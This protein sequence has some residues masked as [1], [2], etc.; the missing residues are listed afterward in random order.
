MKG[1]RVIIFAVLLF[2][3]AISSAAP[4]VVHAQDQSSS[5]NGHSYSSILSASIT[6]SA[7][8]QSGSL[9]LSPGGAVYLYAA[10]TGGGQPISGESYAVDLFVSN[11]NQYIVGPVIAIGHSSNNTGS[12]STA[13]SYYAIGG[14]RVTS[15]IY[16]NYTFFNDSTGANSTSGSFSVTQNG[17]LVVLVSAASNGYSGAVTSNAPF[18]YDAVTSGT[19]GN[20]SSYSGIVI[21]SATVGRGQYSFT[22]NYENG[23]GSSYA[24]SV[25]A[26]IYIFSQVSAREYNVTFSESGLPS[27]SSWYVNLSNGLSYDSS[28]SLISFSA[29]NGTYYYS[30]GSNTAYGAFPPS[31]AFTVNGSNVEESVIF[32]LVYYN[33]TFIESGLPVGT[34]WSVTL[35]ATTESSSTPILTFNEPNGKYSFEIGKV[36][37]Y[38]SSPSSGTVTVNGGNVTQSISFTPEKY[39]A[40]FME[41]GLPSGTAWSV[42]L[43]GN[44]LSSNSNSITF[45]VKDGVYPYSV[46]SVN[47]FT[48]SPSNGTVNVNGNNVTVSI[49]FRSYEITFREIGLPSGSSW[50]ISVNGLS[51]SSSN[52]SISIKEGNGTYAFSVENMTGYRISPDSG[53]VVVSGKNVSLLITFSFVSPAS[54][55]V[56]YSPNMEM[57][58]A[59]VLFI[60]LTMVVVLL[61]RGEQNGP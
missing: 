33:V 13:A 28:T 36:T 56:Y 57:A 43:N 6:A 23:P 2:A 16:E 9:T 24:S 35:S 55:S 14:A 44:S 42:I 45:S 17:S 20:A 40:T 29:Y 34:A 52:G 4:G 61:R 48:P 18:T 31:G 8:S 32:K 53:K 19:Y 3:I 26:V 25:G 21:A 1:Y 50:E 30:I 39:S 10:V 51:Y 41:T 47:G 54:L 59:F 27:G 37:G 46:P 22:V 58:F 60:V 12:F 38:M 15:L 7:E 5:E 11:S 49:A